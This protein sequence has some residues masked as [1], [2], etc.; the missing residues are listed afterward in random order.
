MYRALGGHDPDASDGFIRRLE[1][2]GEV[3]RLGEDGRMI[4][5]LTSSLVCG[6]QPAIGPTF[7]FCAYLK[8]AGASLSRQGL[9]NSRS[10]CSSIVCYG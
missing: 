5:Q 9:N 6:G 7:G 2:H 8:R 3:P 4:S 1:H 10:I